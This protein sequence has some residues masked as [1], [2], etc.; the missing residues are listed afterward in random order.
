MRAAQNF[1]GTNS[2]LAY[3][4]VTV[5]RDSYSGGAPGFMIYF[6]FVRNPMANARIVSRHNTFQMRYYTQRRQTYV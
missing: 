1:Q 6:G 5:Y 4:N 2:R 3:R